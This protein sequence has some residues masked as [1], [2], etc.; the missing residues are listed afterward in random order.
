LVIGAFGD[1][2]SDFLTDFIQ[3]LFKLS[4]V[5]IARNQNS[6]GLLQ[7]IQLFLNNAPVLSFSAHLQIRGSDNR[8]Q[9]PA[10]ALRAR[11][12]HAGFWP[13]LVRRDVSMKLFSHFMEL[14]SITT[15]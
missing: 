4:P 11:S 14:G 8:S 15:S 2:D 10:F 5:R 7:T 1:F 6:I 13:A 3:K 12:R 9:V